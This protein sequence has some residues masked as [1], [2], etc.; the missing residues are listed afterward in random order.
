MGDALREL[1]RRAAR[2]ARGAAGA[3]FALLCATMVAGL[4]EYNFGDS[5]ILMLLLVVSA[6]PYALRRQR[7]DA[8][9]AA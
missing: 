8:E 5:E 2:A 9:A 4:F 3:A 6:A 7:E 1:R